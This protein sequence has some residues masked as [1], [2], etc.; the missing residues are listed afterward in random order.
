VE[1]AAAATDGKCISAIT[2][3]KED[4]TYVFQFQTLRRVCLMTL[5]KE[6]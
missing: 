3:D 2:K 6:M 5:Q 1:A 4:T